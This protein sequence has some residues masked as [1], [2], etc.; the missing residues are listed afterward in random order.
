MHKQTPKLEW[1]FSESDAEW[2]AQQALL[3]PAV[4]AADSRRLRLKQSVGIV[5]TT[6]LFFTGVA[7]W[8]RYTTQAKIHAAE[9]ELRATVAQNPPMSV[10]PDAAPLTTTINHQRTS[11][12]WQ[13]H[14]GTWAAF[15]W[16]YS[17]SPAPSQ[18]DAPTVPL[19]VI[20]QTMEFL[21]EQAIADVVMLDERGAPRYRQTR[22][23]QH[24]S[25]GWQIMPPAA[26]LWGE[27][28]TLTTPYF[29]Y[30]FRQRDAA[31][32][33]AVAPQIDALY[34]S[35]W[36]NFGLPLDPMPERLVIDVR[37]TQPPGQAT[38]FD[39]ANHLS[40]ASPAL[41]PIWRRSM[42]Y[43]S[44]SRPTPEARPGWA[45]KS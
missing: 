44:W 22:F 19:N 27:E 38:V 39:G 23:Y 2:A 25:S 10:T 14:D 30:H 17:A 43:L 24:L 18:P 34:T 6:L 36:R 8:W 4:T 16:E 5:M 7:G 21:G 31:V 3:L 33:A 20:V 28:R 26:T 12:A 42:A 11:S 45:S 1:R 29:V 32:V 40:V 37:V 13:L 35:M 41:Y 9:A 15:G